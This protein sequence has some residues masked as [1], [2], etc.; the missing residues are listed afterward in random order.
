MVSRF[1]HITLNPMVEGSD[2]IQ[3]LAL[4]SFGKI[5]I[6]NR[7]SPP[8]GGRVPGNRWGISKCSA[9]RRNIM[10]ADEASL[11]KHNIFV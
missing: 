11:G 1:M 6:N 7:H 8:T 3:A 5:L 4:T 9:L 2:P 10:E